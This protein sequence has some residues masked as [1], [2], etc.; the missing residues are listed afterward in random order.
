VLPP[1]GC[2]DPFCCL[3]EFV[4][5][6]VAAHGF[7]APSSPSS[8][9]RGL[10]PSGLSRPEGLDPSHRLR[11]IR[12][13][14]VGPVPDPKAENA[15][16]GVS[17][18][19]SATSMC[20]SASPGFASPGTFRPRSFTLPR[21]FAPCTPCGP[22]RDCCRS[23]GS[24]LRDCPARF[25]LRVAARCAPSALTVPGSTPSSSSEEQEVKGPEDHAIGSAERPLVWSR[26]SA[27]WP[28]ALGLVALC[29]SGAHRIE[30][31]DRSP[32][33]PFRNVPLAAALARRT[34]V[35]CR[36]GLFPSCPESVARSRSVAQGI[37]HPPTPQAPADT[38][39]A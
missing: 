6:C 5:D 12:G 14:P 31:P 17:S 10:P 18:A 22:R 26:S 2:P 21:R 8:R 7:A 38:V 13:P 4:P 19:P 36:R 16:P 24:E 3:S 33:R 35:G 9:S 25:A 34:R 20:R 29:R 11:C 23:W 37:P 28:A 30:C 1:S 32:R 15:P 39:S 27:P